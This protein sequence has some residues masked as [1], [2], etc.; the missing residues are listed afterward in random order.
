[1][2]RLRRVQDRRPRSPHEQGRHPGRGRP[3]RK[4]RISIIDNSIDRTVAILEGTGMTE[5][6]KKC[7]SPTTRSAMPSAS[8]GSKV[9]RRGLEDARRCAT[10][11]GEPARAWKQ[12]PHALYGHIPGLSLL[13]FL[14]PIC[15][16]L[17]ISS[18]SLCHAAAI[19]HNRMA[20]NYR[21]LALLDVPKIICDFI[22][23]LGNPPRGK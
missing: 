13:H 23:R 7:S 3:Q 12:G 2:A 17:H 19:E 21:M 9:H 14:S 1:L 18:P 20:P 15:V 6:R 5:T 10:A 8:R 22:G 16:P 11:I 4:D